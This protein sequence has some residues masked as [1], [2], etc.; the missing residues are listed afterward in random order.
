MKT[1]T[2]IKCAAIKFEG[3]VYT[4]KRH[5]DVIYYMVTECGVKP[6]VDNGIQG[7]ID[8]EGNFYD[9]IEAKKIAVSAGQLIARASHRDELFSE[10][11]Y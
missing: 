9:R 4:G 5:S 6:P 1:K 11:I 2:K 7:F 10:D 8:F 3:E